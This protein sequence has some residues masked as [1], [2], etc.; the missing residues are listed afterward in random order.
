MANIVT[1]KPLSKAANLY[2]NGLGIA[3]GTT[4]TRIA[5]SA[6]AARDSTN[7]ADIVLASDAIIIATNT[8][9]NGLDTG[10]LAASTFYYVYVIGSSLS[11][12]PE[13]NIDKQYS[14][15]ASGTTVLNGTVVAEG[16]VTPQPAYTVANNLQPAGLLSLSATA[17]TLPTGYDMFR[18]VG[19]VL[20]SGG[21]VF[22]PFFQDQSNDGVNR[23]M[24]YDTPISVLAATAAA[25][26]TAQSLAVAVP[27]IALSGAFTEVTVQADL[28]PNAAANFVQMRPTG[29]AAAAGNVKMS[30]S[31]AGVHKFDQLTVIAG[32]SAGA[33]SIDWMTDA[34]S[35][36]ALTVSAYV[37]KL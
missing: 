29:G 19:A 16:Q 28:L 30:G 22:L 18:R 17:P 15:L 2:V 32:V 6:G 14:L 3:P 35:T 31:V 9:A 13:I 25:A 23:K 5:L 12:N 8:G 1:G 7:V 20:T 10:A 34:A 27:V 37:D 24:W 26:M 11:A 4:T 33:A 36:V 21:S